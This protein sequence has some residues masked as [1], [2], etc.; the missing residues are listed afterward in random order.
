[1]ITPFLR[2]SLINTFELCQGRAWLDYGIGLRGEAGKAALIGSC[3]H[4]VLEL[5]GC[6]KLAIQNKQDHFE[7]DSFG[8]WQCS[9]LAEKF[10]STVLDVVYRYY[11]ENNSGLFDGTSYKEC[12]KIVNQA[13]ELHDGAFDP[14]NS[15]IIAVEYPFDIQVDEPWGEYEYESPT[16]IVKGRL[17]LKGTV[18]QIS[19]ED[20][21]TIHILDWKTGKTT[22]NWATD[23][24]K[25]L[26]SLY[27]DIQLQLYYYALSKCFPKIENV[28][29]TLYFIRINTP[30][31][32]GFDRSDLPKVENFIREKYEEILS[33]EN[34]KFIAG[35]KIGW[36]C[37]FCAHSKNKQSGTN[38]S[39]CDFFQEQLRRYGYNKTMKKF[40]RWESI[41]SYGSGGSSKDRE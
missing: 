39:V 33:V 41:N 34:P 27:D 40:A 7:H 37:R 12:E 23:K 18:D 36:K 16:G 31:T 38:K 21:N 25:D 24:E 9:V 32:I 3:V 2:S 26:A 11:D 14:R 29:I 6:Q 1:M 10:P 4:G 5:F 8:H 20:E 17:S 35:T 30:F 28:L 19:Y 13:L 15:N 22:K